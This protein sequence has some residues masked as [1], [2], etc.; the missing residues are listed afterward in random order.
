MTWDSG[1]SSASQEELKIG[2]V[3]GRFQP[4]HLGHMNYILAAKKK[5]DLLFVG[6]TNPDPYLTKKDITNP[7]R[8]MPIS[9]PFSYWQRLLM[10][11]AA[12]PEAGIDKAVFRVVPFPINFPKRIRFY[13]P[14]DAKYFVTIYDAWGRRKVEILKS[15]GLDVEVLWERDPSEKGIDGAEVRQLMI[16]NGDW[17]SLVPPSVVK[18]ISDFVPKEILKGRE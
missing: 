14:R 3:H 15:V 12:L 18:V 1:L 7:L 16:E 8:S 9:N 6:I 5:C 13:S 11:E 17:K 10:I 4:L 2:V